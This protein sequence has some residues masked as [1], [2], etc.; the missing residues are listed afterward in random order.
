MS[1]ISPIDPGHLAV[2]KSLASLRRRAKLLSVACGLGIVLATAVGLLLLLAAV[3]YLL[4][5]QWLTRALCVGAALGALLY[6]FWERVLRPLMARMSLG[7]V[8][9]HVENVFPQFDDRLR[10]TVYFVGGEVPGS[11]IMKQRT[12]SEAQRLA[13]QLDLSCVLYPKPVWYSL[14]AAAV[15]AGIA[16]LLAALLGEHARIALSRILLV[17]S[18][19]WPK[20][21][22]IDVV[23]AIPEKVAAGQRVDFRMRLARGERRGVKPVLYYRYDN[24]PLQQVLM[25]RGDDGVYTAAIDA[26]GQQMKVWMAAG[27]DETEPRR[28]TVVQRLAINGV[29][30]EV[31]PPAYCRMEPV[32]YNLSQAPAVV[33]VGSTVKMTVHFNKPLAPDKPVVLES[34]RPDGKMPPVSWVK[35]TPSTAVG[36]WAADQSM[37]FRVH[38]IDADYFENTGLEEYEI[39]VRPDQLPSVIIEI[40]RGNEDRTPVAVVRLEALAEDDFDISTMTLVVDRPADKKHWEIPLSNWQRVDA[41]GERRRFRV[42][43]DWELAQLPDAAL[44]P[45]DVLEYHVQVTDNYDLNGAR[46][47]PAVSGRLRINIIS[48]EALSIQITDAMRALA[49]RV[50][51]VQNTQNRTQQE[52]ASLRKETEGK[53]ALDAGERTALN[54]L[55][56]QQSTMVSQTRQLAGQ[57]ADLERRLEDNRSDNQELRD[58]AREVRRGLTETAENPMTSAAH[59]LSEA[60]QHADPRKAGGDP[61]RQQALAEQRNRAMSDSEARQR[62]SSDQLGRVLEKMGTLGTFEQ[63]LQRVREALARQQELS[64]QLGELG[65]QTLGKDPD[66]LSPEEK[67][68]LADIAAEQSRQARNTEKLT[69]DLQKAAEQTQRSDQPSSQAMQ[70]A[71][72]QAQQQQVASNQSQAAQAAQQNQQAQAQARQRQAELGLQMML[73]TLREAERRKLEQLA[74]ELAKMQEL[75]AGLIRRQAGHNID[76]L[77][78]QGGQEKLKQI[79]DEL[80]RKAERV[81]DRQPPVPRPDQLMYS[82]AQTEGNTRDVAR[83]AEALRRGGA[84]IAAALTRAAGH[85]E[86]AVVGIKNQQLPEAYDPHQVRSLAALEEALAKADEAARDVNDQLDQ[87]NRETIR[88]AYEKIRAEQ[89]KI[90]RETARIDSAPRLPDGTLRREDAVNLARLPGQQ[91]QLAEQTRKLED[92]LRD[93]GGVV[94][95]WANKDIVESMNEVKGELARPSTGVATQTEQQRILEQ[96]DAMIKNLAVRPPRRSDFHSPPGGGGGGGGQPPRPQLPSEVELR[97]L[98]DLQLAVNKATKVLNALPDKDKPKLVALGGRQGELRGVL[99]QLLQKASRGMVKLDPEPDPA[100]RL[101]EEAGREELDNQEFDE[102]LRGGRSG[103]DQLVNDVKQAGQR[104]GRSRQRLALNHDPG[105]TTQ[106]IQER[107]IQNLDNLIQMARQQQAQASSRQGQP[108]QPGQQPQPGEGQMGQQQTGQPQPNRGSTPASSERRGGTGDTNA[109]LSKDIREKAAEWGTLTPKERQAV[110][111][112]MHDK[113]I[114]KYKRLIDEY[115]EMMSRKR[116]KAD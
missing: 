70:Q 34:V 58:I 112:G 111:D 1:A 9:G 13:A 22:Q 71:A 37:R 54:R 26:R 21:V 68:R 31:T 57:M 48:Q 76:N 60:A 96:L 33:T 17:K 88:E 65:K 52:T 53:P 36:T 27:D 113:A 80:L 82:Q 29:E 46:H 81:A 105:K 56:E 64:R 91:G 41:R 72:Q 114:P 5:L 102:W 38:A 109:D 24:G 51:Q 30:L 45:G 3:D 2:L 95:V 35:P 32:V 8:A 87:A 42:K 108:S 49:E 103:D 89:E 59:R 104:M 77:R 100:E 10:S 62:E 98:K 63:M 11:E 99:D 4:R 7:D 47:E 16:I 94:Y 74:R 50:R 115:Y 15:A 39:T 28:I 23:R 84:E 92:P 78:I 110:I 90:N 79:T 69:A 93:L 18:E 61:Q 73:D 20:R 55:T 19:D 75:I 85:M 83:S 12:V 97:L 66:K 116:S 106:L 107:I 86:R 101:P 14:G 67:K 43:Y 6:L 40:P 25:T 44:K